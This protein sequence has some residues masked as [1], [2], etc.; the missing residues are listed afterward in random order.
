MKYEEINDDHFIFLSVLDLG[1]ELCCCIINILGGLT[2]RVRRLSP[3][4]AG[5]P[6]FILEGY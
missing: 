3:V 5:Y 6:F 4:R 2:V 1:S